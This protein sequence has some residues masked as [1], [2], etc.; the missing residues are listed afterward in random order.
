MKKVGRK[1]ARIV[2]RRWDVRSEEALHS[3]VD[4]SRAGSD[5]L[6]EVYERAVGRERVDHPAGAL[7]Q[8]I[9]QRAGPR[10]AR[11]ANI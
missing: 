1:S 3:A 2:R 6:L 11:R 7:G 5:E 8:E 9:E 10:K 4:P